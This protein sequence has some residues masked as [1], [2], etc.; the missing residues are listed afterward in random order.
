MKNNLWR[1]CALVM[2]LFL[3]GGMVATAQSASTP[4]A[5]NVPVTG[6]FAGGGQFSGSITI[7][8]FEQRG[9]DI[10]AIGFVSGVL[11]RGSRSLGTGLAGEL[12]WPVTIKSSA[13]ST[14]AMSSV[15]PAQT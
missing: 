8:R 6:T 10:V 11:S 3:A 2:V 12:T 14:H 13:T 1:I 15:A 5:V 7:N 4:K 9:N